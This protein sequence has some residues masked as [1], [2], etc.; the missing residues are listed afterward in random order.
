LSGV[1]ANASNRKRRLDDCGVR[2]SISSLFID[3]GLLGVRLRGCERALLGESLARAGVAERAM[4]KIPRTCPSFCGVG[5]NARRMNAGVASTGGTGE[6]PTVTELSSCRRFE[7]VR[8]GVDAKVLLCSVG[9]VTSF[10]RTFRGVS[11][12]AGSWPFCCSLL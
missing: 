2:V 3:P 6:R 7:G 10:R 8:F 4:S 5:P 11:S 12:L 1:P 9:F